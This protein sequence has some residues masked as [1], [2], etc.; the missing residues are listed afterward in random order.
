MTTQECQNLSQELLGHV[1]RIQSVTSREDLISEAEKL[2]RMSI[3]TSASTKEL[4]FLIIKFLIEQTLAR[5]AG[6]IP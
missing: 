5:V 1:T 6:I 4:Q 3:R 2:S